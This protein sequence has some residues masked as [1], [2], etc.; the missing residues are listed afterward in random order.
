MRLGPIP[1][2]VSEGAACRVFRNY[3]LPASERNDWQGSSPTEANYASVRYLDRSP[4][5]RPA[6]STEIT[7]CQPRIETTDKGIRLPTLIAP[8]PS[9]DKP[10]RGDL[11]RRL[12]CTSPV[13]RLFLAAPPLANILHV[14]RSPFHSDLRLLIRSYLR[15][16]WLITCCEIAA[17]LGPV[18][19]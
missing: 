5:G 14:L 19:G 18:V 13:D 15:F 1:R 8:R 3:T 10:P 12:F 2:Q 11:P 9:A 7:P 6:G 4:R 17:I 16:L